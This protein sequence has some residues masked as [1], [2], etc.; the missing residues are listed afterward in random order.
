VLF[1][2]RQVSGMALVRSQP[3]WIKM[4]HQFFDPLA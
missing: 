1:A 2:S 3:S 4:V